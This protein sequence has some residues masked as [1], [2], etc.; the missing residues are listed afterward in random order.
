MAAHRQTGHRRD[1]NKSIINKALWGE[2]PAKGEE[3]GQPSRGPQPLG[4][5]AAP[6]PTAMG[7]RGASCG[8]RGPWRGQLRPKSGSICQAPST[9]ASE[10]SA[11]GGQQP[12]SVW[13]PHLPARKTG[14]PRHLKNKARDQSR[15]LDL[16]FV[17][18]RTFGPPKWV[19]VT[20]VCL[21]AGKCVC[22]L[23]LRVTRGQTLTTRG[24]TLMMKGQT[25]IDNEGTDPDDEGTDPDR[26]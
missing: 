1:G 8:D 5:P 17:T 9:K 24:Q 10:A 3:P 6:R 13:D 22:V 4:G 7:S 12:G 14:S 18:D 19:T 26:K 11:W 21:G 20:L 15:R 25:L 16:A 2:R 23:A